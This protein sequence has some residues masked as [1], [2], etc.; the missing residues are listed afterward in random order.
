MSFDWKHLLATVAPTMAGMVGTPLTGIA[1]SAGLKAF[2]IEPS[3]DHKADEESLGNAMA[4]ATPEQLAVIKKADNDF[5]VQM[6]QLDIDDKKLQRL[7]DKDYID[8][9]SDARHVHADNK[10]VFRLGIAIIVGFFIVMAAVLYGGYLIITG[11]IAVAD[12]GVFGAVMT[13]VGTVIGYLA[14]NAQQVVS[15]CFGSS[16]G[17]KQKTDV[18]AKQFKDVRL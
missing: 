17:S 5:K 2:G 10:S 18:L 3:G 6:R 11:G 8:D 1:V 7:Q 14:G 9:T 16:R 4:S 13:I 15:F 12:P